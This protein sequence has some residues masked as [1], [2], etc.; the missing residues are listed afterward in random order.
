MRPRR[1]GS[2]VSARASAKGPGMR[3][4]YSGVRS[5]PAARQPRHADILA[6]GGARCAAG[7]RPRLAGAVK[8][9]PKVHWRTRSDLGFSR[10]DTV[11][12]RRRMRS[13]LRLPG[14]R[15]KRASDPAHGL[16][17][18]RV[19]R[20]GVD[21]GRTDLD[22]PRMRWITCKSTCCSLS[23]VPEVCRASCRRASLVMPASA[24]GA[25]YWSQST[26]GR[27]ARRAEF[28][29]LPGVL[30]AAGRAGLPARWA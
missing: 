5:A 6:T 16:A 11:S 15:P 3:S 18:H 7:D 25:F 4:G 29:A 14:I 21:P 17:G 22:V 26:W 20:V 13:W 19:G 24:V 2:Y 28:R 23:M 1:F 9:H 8:H 12:R 30:S 10:L 27:S